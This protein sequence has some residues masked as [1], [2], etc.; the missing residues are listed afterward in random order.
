MFI[1][2]LSLQ[3]LLQTGNG[4]TRICHPQARRHSKALQQTLIM[5]QL[6]DINQNG[7]NQWT[8]VCVI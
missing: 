8:D 3:S 4:W 5:K 2:E 7:C 6:E 1:L